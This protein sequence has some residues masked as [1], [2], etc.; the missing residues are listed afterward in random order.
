MEMARLPPD[1][2]A[3]LLQWHILHALKLESELELLGAAWLVLLLVV[4]LEEGMG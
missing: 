3:P 4:F 2:L 1:Q